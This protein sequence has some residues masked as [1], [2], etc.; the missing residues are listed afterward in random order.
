MYTAFEK[1][2]CAD[3]EV[4]MRRWVY[5]RYVADRRMSDA[6]AKRQIALMQEIA[7]DYKKQAEQERLL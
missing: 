3:D 5:P 1:M 4:K 6:D 2:K 7:E